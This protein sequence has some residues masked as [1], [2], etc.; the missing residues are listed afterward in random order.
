[1]PQEHPGSLSSW[2]P[3]THPGSCHRRVLRPIS[4][5]GTA[6]HSQ[7]MVT[8]GAKKCQTVPNGPFAAQLT[9]SLRSLLPPLRLLRRSGSVVP[10][11]SGA[12][13]FPWRCASK[14]TFRV[15]FGTRWSS[16]VFSGA[17][18]D[19]CH[20]VPNDTLQSAVVW[21]SA[22]LCCLLF[23]ALRRSG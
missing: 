16:L 23:N 22:P 1:V 8:N 5:H 21:I 11:Q 9:R 15:S 18:G 14:F 12:S 7:S 3:R 17:P 19:Q 6:V 4:E 20:L 10:F 2:E 13:S